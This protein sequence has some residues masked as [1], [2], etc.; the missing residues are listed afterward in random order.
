MAITSSDIQEQILNKVDVPYFLENKPGAS[1]ASS[2]VPII[3][4]PMPSTSTL[5]VFIFASS[6][7][8]M[9]AGLLHL[10]RD[11][12]FSPRPMH[13]AIQ[14]YTHPYIYIYVHMSVHTR[15]YVSLYEHML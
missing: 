6:G 10:C 12:I 1:E 4:F 5:V 7:D 2:E 8:L 11:S 9:L 13:V 3:D 15:T 14:R